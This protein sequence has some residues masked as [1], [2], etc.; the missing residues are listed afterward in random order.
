MGA[1][2][3]GCARVTATISNSSCNIQLL[4]ITKLPNKSQEKGTHRVWS[5]FSAN[6]T[7]LNARGFL[8]VHL[9]WEVQLLVDVHTPHWQQKRQWWPNKENREIE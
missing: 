6:E 9:L 8:A 3:T 1:S 2:L 7:K 4:L 5:S